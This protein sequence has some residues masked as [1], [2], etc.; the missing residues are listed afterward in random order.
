M[1]T[2]KASSTR[3]YRHQTSCDAVND[4]QTVTREALSSSNRSQILIGGLVLVFKRA[5]RLFSVTNNAF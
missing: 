4:M 2:H 1:R 3:V 5:G